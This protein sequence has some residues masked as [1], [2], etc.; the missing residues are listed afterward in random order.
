MKTS[1][2]SDACAG[3]AARSGRPSDARMP[4][5]AERTEGRTRAAVVDLLLADG[6]L[7]TADLA[8]QLGISPAAVRR[9]LDQLIDEGAV[10]Y[11]RGTGIAASAAVAGPPA[12]IC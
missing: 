10:S 7:T 4:D 8:V 11:A 12:P 2:V 3:T 1:A 6:P 9:H 5:T